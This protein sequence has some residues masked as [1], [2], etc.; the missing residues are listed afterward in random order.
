[1][2][3]CLLAPCLAGLLAATGCNNT[4]PSS[5]PASR[6]TPSARSDE[7]PKAAIPAAKV[8]PEKKPEPPTKAEPEEKKPEFKIGERE[9]PG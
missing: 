4:P 3:K 8:E 1:M 9:V 6:P 2:R 5:G 7:S